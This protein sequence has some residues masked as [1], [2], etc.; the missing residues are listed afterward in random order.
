M[1]ASDLDNDA[2]RTG[3]GPGPAVVLFDL[4]DTLFAHR[5]AVAEG[6]V[7]HLGLVGGRFAGVD[8]TD[9]RTLWD[10]LE[11][12]HYHSY[13]AGTL[14]FP[15]Q[16]RAR[17]RDF[18]AAHGVDLSDGEAAAWFDAYFVHYR[19]SWRLHEDALSCLD[20]LA[21][22]IPGVRFG[23]ITNG[24]LAFQREK[25]MATGLDERVE[26]VIASGEL[27]VAKPDPRIFVHACAAFGVGPEAAAY[28]GDR[29]RTDAIGAAAAGLTG[30]WL[31]RLNAKV[32]EADLVEARRLGVIRIT[33]LAALPDVL[34]P[35]A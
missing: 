30:V 3:G 29:L 20:E 32:P 23:L 18:A 14:D 6:I 25:L 22:V 1:N 17:A 13:L 15:G 2:G 10:A 19:D 7:R 16:R 31:D 24:E 5:G 9:A 33:A 12:K 4:D 11:E 35:P 28:V 34:A 27:D 26:H 21:R 8:S